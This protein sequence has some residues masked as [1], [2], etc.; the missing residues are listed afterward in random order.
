MVFM[1]SAINW[2]D[3]LQPILQVLLQVLLPVVLSAIAVWVKQLIS[4]AKAEIE[5][6]NLQWLLALAQQFVLAAEQA[7]VVGQ[8]EDLGEEKKKMVIELLQKAADSRG[9]KLDVSVLSAIVEAAVVSAFGFSE[10][11]T[12]G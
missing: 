9:L 10:P 11:S 4:K 6:A 12:E 1:Q 7:G 2:V 3:L 8:I 5:D